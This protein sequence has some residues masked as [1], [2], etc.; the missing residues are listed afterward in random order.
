[1]KNTGKS[2]LRFVLGLVFAAALCATVSEPSEGTSI[3]QW[4]LVHFI[5]LT[6][7]TVTGFA[8]AA[9][10]READND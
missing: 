3:G 8:L 6:V 9:L 7:M 10:S 5:G 2:I 1:M 4:W